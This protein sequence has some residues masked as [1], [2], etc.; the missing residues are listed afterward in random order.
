MAKYFRALEASKQESS[1]FLL[2][3]GE[4]ADPTRRFLLDTEV[5]KFVI[6]DD[7]RFSEP[8][9]E[10]S[11]QNPG[12]IYSQLISGSSCTS[13]PYY[14]SGYISNTCLV[15][16]GYASY[17]FCDGGEFPSLINDFKTV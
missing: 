13:T 4:K 15:N 17:S 10:G 16:D 9:P 5:S 6:A 7:Q 3:N 14:V 2:K 11:Y 8:I 12:Y 1:D